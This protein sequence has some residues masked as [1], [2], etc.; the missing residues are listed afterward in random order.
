MQVAFHVRAYPLPM[1]A[2]FSIRA[3]P[4]PMFVPEALEEG[5]FVFGENYIQ[6]NGSIYAYLFTYSPFCF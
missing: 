2:L 1:V 6:V 4:L 3:Y 5:Q